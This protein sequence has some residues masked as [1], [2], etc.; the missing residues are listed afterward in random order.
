[1]STRG[2]EIEIDDSYLV[3][4][5]GREEERLTPFLRIPLAKYTGDVVSHNKCGRLCRNLRRGRWPYFW[6]RAEIRLVKIKSK[7]NLSLPK[8][9]NF[10]QHLNCTKM[11]IHTWN[12]Y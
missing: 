4:Q 12:G 11:Y 8:I 5:E 2:S 1:M 7:L 10:D 3:R 6:A 9:I